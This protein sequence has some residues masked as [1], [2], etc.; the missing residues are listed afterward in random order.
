MALNARNSMAARVVLAVVW[1]RVGMAMPSI[2]PGIAFPSSLSGG[3]WWLLGGLAL[4]YAVAGWCYPLMGV[5][6]T[7]ILLLL[8]LTDFVL[9]ATEFHSDLGG[10]FTEQHSALVAIVVL[11]ALQFVLALI[12]IGVAAW[13]IRQHA[14]RRPAAS[15]MG[16]S[17]LTPDGVLVRVDI[18]GEGIS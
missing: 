8:G 2:I 9:T 15:V 18:E 3:L 10:P 4:V 13:S 7:W 14:R 16:S 12:V 17:F 6:G 11:D 1:L 5:A